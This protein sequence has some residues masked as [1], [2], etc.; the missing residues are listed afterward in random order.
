MGMKREHI[1]GVIRL[2]F[3][4]AALAILSVAC[5]DPQLM[6]I[7][8]T[9]EQE[10]PLVDTGLSN[11][12]M[13]H[14]VVTD[15]TNYYAAAGQVFY[16]AV[17]STDWHKAAPPVSGALCNNLAYFA[18]NL[19]GG[20]FNPDGTSLGL[21]YATNPASFN[22]AA[23]PTGG[24][25]VDNE[26]IIMLKVAGPYLFV[27]TLDAN[28]YTLHYTDAGTFATTNLTS[29]SEMIDDIAYDGTDYWVIAG[30]ELYSAASLLALT[31]Q[32]PSPSEPKTTKPFGGV[33]YS[34]ANTTTY[35]SSKDGNLF[36]HPNGGAWSA[37]Q[38]ISGSPSFTEFAELTGGDIVVGSEGK[39]YY[40]LQGGSISSAER[41]PDYNIADLY[42]AVVLSFLVD[43]PNKL[44]AGTA[45]NGLWRSND[46]GATGTWGRE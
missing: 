38:A 39:G 4:G 43:V 42:N 30:P 46:G 19:Y 45:R 14:R 41:K 8:Y 2:L 13:V 44:F 34:S 20:F 23:E 33:F 28:G 16:R 36:S 15:G 32:N 17:G 29:L 35:L 40:L 25:L 26:Q 3:L 21:R 6:P 18:P 27:T 22:W 7:F 12:L 10:T 1:S 37:A 9:L 31:L 5:T 11:E 24:A